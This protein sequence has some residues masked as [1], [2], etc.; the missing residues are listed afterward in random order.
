M[1]F[2]AFQDISRKFEL[3]WVLGN[4]SIVNISSCCLLDWRWHT[5]TEHAS[6]IL[7]LHWCEAYQQTHSG[8][9]AK[10]H[11]S[12]TQLSLAADHVNALPACSD[13]FFVSVCWSDFLKDEN[14]LKNTSFHL[15]SF[16]SI[17]LISLRQKG[18]HLSSPTKCKS[19]STDWA[20]RTGG[21]HTMSGLHC[22]LLVWNDL[23][24]NQLQSMSQVHDHFC[25][26]F[27][28][29][30]HVFRLGLASHVYIE[31][32]VKIFLDSSNSILMVYDGTI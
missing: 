17:H 12:A 18:H 11:A 2:E 23:N 26:W 6:R 5:D 30:S 13:V 20:G 16:L 4:S 32:C 21:A 14:I 22:V 31:W 29:C 19:S 7:R 3:S 9:E 24:L 25:R 8:G 1:G 15:V 10:H 27:D 28:F